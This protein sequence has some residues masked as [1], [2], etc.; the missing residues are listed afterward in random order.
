MAPLLLEV[1]EVAGV[2]MFPADAVGDG[3]EDI[4]SMPV[5]WIEVCPTEQI[6]VK[7]ALSNSKNSWKPSR[8]KA[9]VV[10]SKAEG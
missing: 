1:V 7:T 9:Q 4:M 8:Y 10:G 5:K 6:V 2:L 3:V